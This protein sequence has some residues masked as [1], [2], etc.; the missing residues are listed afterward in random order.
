MMAFRL[1]ESR[2]PGWA[3]VLIVA[4]ASLTLLLA[5]LQT[6]EPALAGPNGAASATPAP[7]S[8]FLFRF[9]PVARTFYTLTLPAGSLPYGVAVTGTNPTHVWVALYGLDQIGRLIYT[10]TNNVSWKTFPLASNS[11]PFRLSVHGNFVWFTERGSNRIG[12]LN[13]VTGQVDEF[14]GNGLSANSG[15]ADIEVAPNG[16]VWASG[17]ASN[18]L[19]R[20]VVTATHNFREYSHSSMTGIFGLA[21]ESSEYIW[22]TSPGTN[23]VGRLSVP[24][25][26]IADLSGF[27]PGGGAPYEI[28]T[29]PGFA[30][31]TDWQRNAIGQVQLGTLTNLRYYTP[32]TRPADLASESSNRFWF[33]QQSNQGALGRFIYTSTMFTSLESFPLPSAG[34]RPTGIA[35]AADKGVWAVAFAPF[36]IFLPV[37]LKNTSS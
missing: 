8:S 5:G 14:F 19:I 20:L 4:A 32:T 25:S 26:S 7:Q 6:F 31:F 24:N 1:S 30:W 27:I 17:Q 15:L 35:V 22:Y 10:S 11:R 3:I 28:V 23:N 12:R 18:R 36:R 13:A 16:W 9:D 37:I 29:T 2:L 21:V 33:T 34:L